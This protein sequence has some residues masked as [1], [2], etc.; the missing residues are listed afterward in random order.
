VAQ[1]QQSKLAPSTKARIPAV[2]QVECTLLN[3]RWVTEYW[4]AVNANV[5]TPLDGTHGY[6]T[7]PSGIE[8]AA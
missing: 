3:V 4:S 1:L 5:E 7:G 2:E 6:V 8:F